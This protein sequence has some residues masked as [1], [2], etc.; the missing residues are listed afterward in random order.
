M[1]NLGNI[2]P[3]KIIKELHEEY[4]SEYSDDIKKVLE[5]IYYP[6]PFDEQ[7][8]ES[9]KSLGIFWERYYSPEISEILNSFPKIQRALF[10][11]EEDFSSGSRYR[12]HYVHMFNV[13]ITGARII[14]KIIDLCDNEN[15]IEEVFKIQSEPED[16]P[17]P[18]PYKKIERLF[19]LWVLISTFHDIGIPIE[20]LD[21]IKNGINKFIKFFGLKI[22]TL[23]PIK[24][25]TI[26]EQAGYFIDNMSSFDNV[27]IVPINGLY[28]KTPNINNYL[29]QCLLREFSNNNHGVISAVCL[30]NSF[31]ETFLVGKHSKP[32]YD[33][34]K[35]QYDVFTEKIL[36]Q[37]VS[38]AALA[39]AYH[40]IKYDIYPKIFPVKSQSL[41]L[42][43][44]LIL[45]DE[46]QEAFRHEG[47]NFIGLSKL[48]T[49]PVIDVKKTKGKFSITITIKYKELDKNEENDVLKQ[50]YNYSKDIHDSRTVNSFEDLIGLTWDNIFSVLTNKLDFVEGFFD[51]RIQVYHAKKNNTKLICNK[52][53]TDK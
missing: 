53:F 19:F 12:D 1:K 35:E 48:N 52:T 2:S 41:P 22:D 49:F 51:V 38:R 37:D 20:H 10:G 15:D 13:F 8:E 30:F 5:C 43:F 42:T 46:I 33:L 4:F 23:I 9:R 3:D 50:Y 11:L 29:K 6:K 25:H 27:S 17:F 14:S 34:T 45:C 40:N 16:I 28:K 32:T 26:I 24:D 7:I 18:K 21:K 47:I 36:E 31:I 39:I 44:I